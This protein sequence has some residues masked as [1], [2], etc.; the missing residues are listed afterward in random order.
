MKDNKMTKVEYLAY[1]NGYLSSV[2]ILNSIS[3]C[4]KDFGFKEIDFIEDSFEKSLKTFLVT[5]NWNFR[6]KKLEE[7]WEEVLLN[8]LWFFEAIIIKNY[9]YPV[10]IGNDKYRELVENHNLND[11]KNYFIRLI[12]E[13]LNLYNSFEVFE[14]DISNQF[15]HQLENEGYFAHGEYNVLFKTSN[16]ELF[17]LYF[18]DSD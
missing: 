17:L 6:F 3:N 15:N 16:N 10:Q 2:E 12:S 11:I 4:E 13:F 9:G 8:N 1:L 14:V 7:N 18:R 5:P